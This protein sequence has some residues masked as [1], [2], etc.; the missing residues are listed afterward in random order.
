MLPRSIATFTLFA[1]AILCVA[2]NLAAQQQTAELTGQITD[3]SG[4]AVP[5]ATVTITNAARGI[6]VTVSS[7]S[8]GI[9]VVPLLSP[10]DNYE[11]T[12]S[13]AGFQQLTRSGVTLQVAQTATVNLV[14]KVGSSNQTVVVTGAPPLLDA[15]TSSIGQVIQARTIAALPLNGRSS[16]RLIQLT[17]GVTFNQ[18]AYGQFGDVPVNTTWDTS[19]SVDGGQAQSNEILIDGVPSEVGFFNQITTIPSVDATEEFKV[20][21]NDLSAEYGRFAGGVINVTTKS[22]TNELHGTAFEFLRNSALDA[23]DYFNNLHGL[24]IPPLKMNQYGGALGGPVVLPPLYRGRDKTFF[25]VDYQGTSRIQGTTYINTVPTAAERTGDFSQLLNSKG[26]PITL[27]NPFTTRPDPSKPG[28][29][30]R[31]AFPGNQVGPIDP[32]A[33]NLM[34]YYPL[35][36]TQGAQF[37]GTNNYISNAPM[38]VDQDQGSVRIDQNVSDHYHFFGR[39]GWM[40]TNLTQPNTLGNVASGGAGAVG[41]TKFHNWSFAFDNTVTINPSLLLTVNYGYA[42]WYQA[43]Q[44]RSFGFDNSKLG[45]PSQF[46]SS[47]TIPM[48]PSIN[49]TGYAPMNGQSYL[50]NGNDSHTVIVSLTKVLS[51]HTLIAG[52]DIRMHLINFFNVGSSAGSFSFAVAQTQGPDPTVASATAGNA[53]ASLLLGAGS[54]GSMPI[55]AGSEMRDWYTAA[56]LQD[57][58]RPTNR[59][60]LNLGLRYET[61]SPYTDRHNKLNYF[62][63]NVPSPARNPSFPNLTGGLEFAG[64]GGNPASVYDWNIAHFEPRLGFAYT[65]IPSTVVRGG[66]GLVYAPLEISN[67]AVGFTPTTG[68]SSTTSWVTST[69]GGLNPANLLSNP[70]PQ[71]LVPPKG[72]SLGAAT[73]LGQSFNV[74]TAHPKT[75]LSYQWNFGIQQQLPSS[76]LVEAAYVASRGMHLTHNFDHDVLNPQYLSMG[77]ALLNKVANPFQPFVS[78]GTLSASTVTQQQLLLPFPQFLDVNAENETW[79]D[80]SYESAQFKVNKRTTHGVSMLAAYTISK[81]LSNVTVADAPIGPTNNSGVQNW[82]DLR[83]E[84]SLSENDTPQALILNVVAELPFGAGERY[85]GGL[86]GPLQ[87][88]IGGWRASGILTEQSGQPLV[89]SAPDTGPGNRPNWV[90]GVN[91]KLSTSRPDSQKVAAYFN[92]GAFSAPAP[93]QFGDVSRTTG[94]VRSPGVKNLDFSLVKQ[95]QLFERLNMEFRAE[96]FNTTNTPHFGLPDTNYADLNGNFG[97]LTSSLASPPPREVQFAVKLRF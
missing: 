97:H 20:E 42:R 24:S 65:V 48:F 44:T 73:Q 61:E 50:L 77:N 17:P 29:Y 39:F 47:V 37:T 52:A 27:F 55:G 19:F 15:Q 83:A 88:L 36:N 3:S 66:A 12:V 4:A 67:N 11:I 1:S 59:L 14:L 57:N 92:T 38:S 89:F 79:G 68:F 13:K 62:S 80:S 74:W 46:V 33:K 58:Y 40:L 93:W 81:W 86:H 56:F 84:K 82:Y 60:T 7:N 16:F 21:S 94:A 96:A 76:I 23:N 87:A 28:K 41:V 35:P 90:T 72:S 49:V 91:P 22:G 63:S 18:G 45:F 53:M 6:K 85:L 70:Y 43:R 8:S 26:A 95:T 10:A 51:R 64:V 2:A 31:D 25:F 75:P 9:Y 71:G 69:N 32:V 5:E 30:V 78:I 34:S 54:S